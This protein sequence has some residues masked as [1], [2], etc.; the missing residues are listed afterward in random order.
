MSEELRALVA[1]RIEQASDSLEVSRL[2]LDGRFFRE[3]VNRSY[4]AMFYAVLALLAQLGLGTSKHGQAIGLFDRE[5]IKSKIFDREFSGWLHEAFELRQ[6]S[7][8]REMFEVSRERA[9]QMLEHAEAFV[10][11]VRKNI[12]KG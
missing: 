12:G 9:E 4:Y 5:F 6:R 7:D 3:S 8:Y 1:Y 11:M 2:A 10:A